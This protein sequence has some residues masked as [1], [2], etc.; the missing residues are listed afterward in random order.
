MPDSKISRALVVWLLLVVFIALVFPLDFKPLNKM[1]ASVRK[2]S[3]IPTGS[4]LNDK[5]MY[6]S[7]LNNKE[8]LLLEGQRRGESRTCQYRISGKRTKVFPCVPPAIL[9]ESALSWSW[10]HSHNIMLTL[11]AGVILE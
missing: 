11:A 3:E 7:L 2:T 8:I 4:G 10:S 5:K 1:T 9:I 6:Y